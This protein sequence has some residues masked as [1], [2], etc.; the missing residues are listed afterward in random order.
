MPL[1][2]LWPLEWTLSNLV[3]GL[4]C[5]N[6]LVV[7]IFIIIRRGPDIGYIATSCT[8]QFQKHLWILYGGRKATPEWQFFVIVFIACLLFIYSNQSE[9][10]VCKNIKWTT[11]K[12][13][14]MPQ[15]CSQT[16]YFR[17]SM[18]FA[19]NLV[20]LCAKKRSNSFLE[21]WCKFFSGWRHHGRHH[22]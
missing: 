11:K 9:P 13:I 15:I 17:F 14:A 16:W 18:D 8:S 2:C 19:M 12:V 5:S 6:S 7:W 3:K 21:D 22:G 20:L 4:W 1:K 10:W